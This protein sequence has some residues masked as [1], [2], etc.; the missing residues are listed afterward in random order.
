MANEFAAMI[1]NIDKLKNRLEHE[2]AREVAT[3]W[4]MATYEVFPRPPWNTGLLRSS[5]TA[6]VGGALVATTPSTGPNPNGS[7]RVR[8]KVTKT[9]GSG[10]PFTGTAGGRSYGNRNI[11]GEVVSTV[12]SPTMTNINFFNTATEVEG[13]LPSTV[14][15]TI[16]VVYRTPYAAMMHE[17]SGGFSSPDSG[18]HYISSKMPRLGT[19]LATAL[20]RVF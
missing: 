5:G 11:Y 6:Y 2:V 19:I 8:K 14:V 7:W 18:A 4:L 20:R 16:S 3:E 1:A 12:E 9:I 10:K 13:N 15:G 17:W